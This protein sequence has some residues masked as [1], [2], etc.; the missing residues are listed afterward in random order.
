MRSSSYMPSAVKLL[1]RMG[2]NVPPPHFVGFARLATVSGLYFAVAWGL[3]MWLLG[4]V[5][6][7]MSASSLLVLAAASLGAGFLFGLSM[8]G[9]YAYGRKKYRLPPWEH[10]GEGTGSA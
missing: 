7:P 2:W 1:W 6:H 9:Y 5:L 8:A 10:L 4:L 3:L